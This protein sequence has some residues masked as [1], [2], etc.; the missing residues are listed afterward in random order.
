MS[1]VVEG[2]LLLAALCGLFLY[3]RWRLYWHRKL[4]PF[5]GPKVA[6]PVIGTLH[7]I[8]GPMSTIL[9]R[10]LRMMSKYGHNEYASFWLGERPWLHLMRPE[11]LEPLMSAAK[12]TTKPDIVY[13]PVSGFFGW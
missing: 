11:D 7:Y 2:L 6:L 8:V 3:C 4:A 12:Q 9:E 10:G 5:G 1:A 13:K